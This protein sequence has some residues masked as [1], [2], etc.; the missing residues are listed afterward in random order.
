[1][2]CLSA[3]HTQIG[4]LLC[5]PHEVLFLRHKV[6]REYAKIAVGPDFIHTLPSFLILTAAAL[7]LWKNPP[8]S[9]R[10]MDLVGATFIYKGFQVQKSMRSPALANTH[11]Y[12]RASFKV[13]VSWLAVSALLWLWLILQR[14]LYCSVWRYW[15]YESEYRDILY[16]WWQH[17]WSSYYPVPVQPPVMSASFISWIIAMSFAIIALGCAN[18]TERLDTFFKETLIKCQ[19]TFAVIKSCV[20]WSQERE[21]EVLVTTE[22]N[23]EMDDGEICLACNNGGSEIL[24]DTNMARGDIH[25]ISYGTNWT[26]QPNFSTFKEAHRKISMKSIHALTGLNDVQDPDKFAAKQVRHRRGCHTVIPSNST[27]QSSEC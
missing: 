5:V 1:M 17:V 27:E 8:S 2:S 20:E 16:P 23:G 22:A 15:S 26:P 25:P 9:T 18:S 6:F 3:L 4:T 19:D 10:L 12:T 11:P 21:Q 14:I 24:N 13:S 7:V